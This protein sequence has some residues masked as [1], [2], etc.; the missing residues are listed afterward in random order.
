MRKGIIYS[1]VIMLLSACSGL[2]NEEKRFK[3][4]EEKAKGIYY[5]T[6]EAENGDNTKQ[7]VEISIDPL[8]IDSLKLSEQKIINMCED[9]LRY[10]DWNVKFKPSYKQSDNAMLT[11]DTKEKKITAFVNGTAE[12]AYG[13]PDELNSTVPFNLKGVMIN[14]QDGLPDIFSF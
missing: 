1:L 13:V 7:Q 3:S 4:I 2:K 11:Y 8:I 10:S 5:L 12:N 14:D 9:A 6:I